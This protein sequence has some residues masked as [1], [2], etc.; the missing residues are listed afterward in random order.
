VLTTQVVRNS[1]RLLRA[2]LTVLVLDKYMAD[3]CK[4][5]GLSKIS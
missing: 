2:K 3:F 5:Q 4:M 1:S